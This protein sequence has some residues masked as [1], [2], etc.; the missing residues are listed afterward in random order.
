MS[1]VLQCTQFSWWMK[2][3][4]RPGTLGVRNHLVDRGRAEVLARVA[5]LLGTHV[6]HRS[7]SATTRWEG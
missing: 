4:F 1:Q 6:A 5:V 7:M 3:F 2:S